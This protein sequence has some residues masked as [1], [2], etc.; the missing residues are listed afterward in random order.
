MYADRKDLNHWIK[1]KRQCDKQ[2]EQFTTDPVTH[3]KYAKLFQ[4]ELERRIKERH[5][6][7]DSV[8]RYQI[9][10]NV[11]HKVYLF[12]G[13]NTPMM[14]KTEYEAALNIINNTQF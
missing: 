4:K 7:T 13:Y 1:Q 10:Q 14:T 11:R 3:K 8:T 9:Y 6:N 5:P 12:F 2:I